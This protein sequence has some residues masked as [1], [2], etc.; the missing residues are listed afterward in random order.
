MDV[1]KFLITETIRQI[2]EIVDATT[3]TIDDNA[4]DGS[5]KGL[6]QSGTDFCIQM[7]FKLLEMNKEEPFGLEESNKAVTLKYI[8]Q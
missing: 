4:Q 8:I 7:I 2:S 5:R 3:K 6:S 1:L